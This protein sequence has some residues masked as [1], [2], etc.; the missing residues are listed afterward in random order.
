MANVHATSWNPYW[1]CQLLHEPEVLAWYVDNS[2]KALP[3]YMRYVEL[4]SNTRGIVVGCNPDG[5]MSFETYSRSSR[6]ELY[7]RTRDAMP[8]H[9]AHI[10]LPLAEG[11]VVTAA[12]IR[13]LDN[14]LSIR[15]PVLVVSN[16]SVCR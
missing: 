14:A 16:I 2:E 13:E 3:E 12:W 11:E 8:A 15:H 4:N 10:C 6:P 9:T 1:D 5:F 7:A